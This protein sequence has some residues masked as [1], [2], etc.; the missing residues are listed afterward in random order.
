MTGSK[1]MRTLLGAN[2]R[3]PKKPQKKAKAGKRAGVWAH[4]MQV[5]GLWAAFFVLNNLLKFL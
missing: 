5:T 2:D 1:R 4:A 3:K